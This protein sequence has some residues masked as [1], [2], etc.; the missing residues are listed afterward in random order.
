MATL[1]TVT[2]VFVGALGQTWEVLTRVAGGLLLFAVIWLVARAIQRV[3]DRA[4]AR[5]SVRADAA[6]LAGRVLYAGMVGLGVFLF[7]AVALGNALVGVAGVLLAAAVTSL[8]LQDLFRNYVS[9]FYIL[10]EGNV[11]IGDLIETGGYRGVVTEVQMRVTYL[12]GAAG[13]VIVVPNSELFTKTLVVSPVP[14][15]WGS[16][17]KPEGPSDPS[18]P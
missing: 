10:T 2:D 12:R 18:L 3:L 13:E 14:P 6:L 1:L 9:G 11:R 16:P 4:L 15:G 8:G 7:V 5:R 17:S